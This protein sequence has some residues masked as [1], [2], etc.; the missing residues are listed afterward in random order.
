LLGDSETSR[1]VDLV[2]GMLGLTAAEIATFG[3][4]TEMYAA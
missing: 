2:T 3:V 4:P 1:R